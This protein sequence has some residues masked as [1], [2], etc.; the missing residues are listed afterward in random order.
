MLFVVATVCKIRQR[1]Q[2]Q[3]MTSGYLLLLLLLQR[4]VG[5]DEDGMAVGTQAA[6]DIKSLTEAD[7]SNAL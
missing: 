4:R 6:I 1:K 5:V 2:Q 3:T 7:R